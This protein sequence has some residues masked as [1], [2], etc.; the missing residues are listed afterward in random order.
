M[1]KNGKN[2]YPSSYKSKLDALRKK[3]FRS[4]GTLI[5][6]VGVSREP[7]PPERKDSLTYR[8]ILPGEVWAKHVYDCG[9]FRVC[10]ALPADRDRK[11]RNP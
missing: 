5:V 4:C 9:W 8:R 1:K 7:T 11:Q 3:T 2:G 10:G 6:S